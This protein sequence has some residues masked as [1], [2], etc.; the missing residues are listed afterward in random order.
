MTEIYAKIREI[1]IKYS[2]NYQETKKSFFTYIYMV[3]CVHDIA[4]PE[5][6]E[7]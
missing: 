3:G 7:F 4:F 2:E 5:L 6:T 1:H